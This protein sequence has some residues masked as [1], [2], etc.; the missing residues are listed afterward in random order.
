M[1]AL[2]FIAGAAIA[3]AIWWYATPAYNDFLCRVLHIFGMFVEAAGRSIT[4]MRAGFTSAHISADQLTYNVVLFA[5]LVAARPPRIL[6]LIAATTI[7]LAIHPLA[8][9]VNVEAAFTK[10]EFWI[11]LDFLYRIGGMFAIAF[12]C[13]YAA[14]APAAAPAPRPGTSR[15]S[16]KEGRAR[17]GTAATPR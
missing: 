14:T 4:A 5:G 17:P 1:R 12:A 16:A 3:F 10:N 15:K 8:V 7:L 6:R 13:W 11:A 9:A 2:R